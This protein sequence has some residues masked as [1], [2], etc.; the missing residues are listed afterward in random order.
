M[1]NAFGDD[2]LSESALG[3]ITRNYYNANGNLTRQVL[4]NGTSYLYAYDTVGNLLSET[5]PLGYTTTFTYNTSNDLTSYTD[6]NGNT[7][8]YAYNS[9][10]IF[11]R[12]HTPMALR[13]NTLTIPWGGDPVSRCGR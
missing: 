3:E 7:T 10:T 6:P 5:D 4:P 9:D 2:A 1:F 13:S 8:D 11:F 12:S